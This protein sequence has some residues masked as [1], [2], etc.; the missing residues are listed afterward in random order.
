MYF[1]LMHVKSISRL[2][3]VGDGEQLCPTQS[4]MNHVHRNA[5]IFTRW[6]PE[7]PLILVSNWPMGRRKRGENCGFCGFTHPSTFHCPELCLMPNLTERE[8]EKSRPTMPRMK[9]KLIFSTTSQYMSQKSL[10][11][12]NLKKSYLTTTVVSTKWR[13]YTSLH[14]KHHFFFKAVLLFYVPLREEKKNNTTN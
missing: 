3:K 6:L 12:D 8:V 1:S 13:Y 7:L 14:L 11:L 5:A 10:V 9:G 4:F 2:E